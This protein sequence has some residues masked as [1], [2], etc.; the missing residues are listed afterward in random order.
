MSASALHHD[1][2][3]ELGLEHGFGTRDE[4]LREGVIRPVQVHGAAVARVAAGDRADPSEADA[5]VAVEPG[6]VIGVV[7]ADCVPILVAS[8]DGR[9]VAAI[10]A[11]WRGLAAGVVERGLRALSARAAEGSLRAVVGPHIGPCCYEVDS[12]VLVALARR[13]GNSALS[14]A[15]AESRPGH[16]MLD[17][18]R[19]IS[20]EFDGF[21]LPRSAQA[22]VAG[23]TQC[24]STRFHSFRRDG[25]RAG[26][27]LHFIKP[28]G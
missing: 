22:R 7:T 20:D 19:L 23:C 18:A 26:R 24:D 28:C 27:L 8:S 11:G 14:R 13:F 12:P 1:L 17:L 5:I 2:L 10:H 16:A 25:D 9:A 3:T 6:H 4:P 21:A 15:T